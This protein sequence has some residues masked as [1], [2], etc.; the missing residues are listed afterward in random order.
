MT[1]ITADG[2][3]NEDAWI[4]EITVLTA[5]AGDF[6]GDYKVRM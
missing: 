5:P 3:A 1:P 2:I 6:E 4:V